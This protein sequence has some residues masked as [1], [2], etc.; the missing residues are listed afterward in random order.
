MQAARISAAGSHNTSANGSI[1]SGAAA[2]FLMSRP[3]PCSGRRHLVTQHG[4]M[5]GQEVPAASRPEVVIR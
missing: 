4:A 1:T 3:Q 5:T 2:L